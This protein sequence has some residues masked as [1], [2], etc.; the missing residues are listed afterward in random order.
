VPLA[1]G[2][3]GALLSPSIAFIALHSALAYVPL[4][5]LLWF[6]IDKAKSLNYIKIVTALAPPALSLLV[7][8][9]LSVMYEGYGS[10]ATFGAVAALMAGYVYVAI[11]WV[12]YL[13]LCIKGTI[14]DE[15]SP[16]GDGAS[17]A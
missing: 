7:A 2:V 17:A 9:V 5:L 16:S 4:S 1:L 15:L 10:I 11:V 8:A 6:C 13:F 12:L 14:N 3:L